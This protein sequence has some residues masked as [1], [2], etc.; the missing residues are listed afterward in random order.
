LGEFVSRAHPRDSAI[1][2][3]HA[4][5][6]ELAFVLAIRVLIEPELDCTVFH[7]GRLAGLG[8][9]VGQPLGGAPEI[10]R[11]HVRADGGKCR[12]GQCGNKGHNNEQLDEGEGQVCM[13]LLRRT[14]GDI[15]AREARHRR[16]AGGLAVLTGEAHS[17]EN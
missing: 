4:R 8:E 14:L 12:H 15:I 11:A 16:E 13:M 2:H 5:A 6:P 9:F 10:D 1:K 7:D 3:H 17:F